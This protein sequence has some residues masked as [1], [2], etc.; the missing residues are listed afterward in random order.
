MSTREGGLSAP[1]RHPIDWENPAFYDTEALN[2]ELERVFDVCHGCRRC[3]SLCES[4][5]VLFDLVDQSTTLE[6]DGVA[7]EDYDKVVD[8]CFL[9]D[10]CY[11]TKCPYVPPHE[12]NI[13]FPHLMLR[14]KINKRKQKKP[15]LS[16]T[17]LS[18]TETVGSIAS[19]PVVRQVVNAANRSKPFRVALEKVLSVH[20]DAAVPPYQRLN[21]KR[22][23]SETKADAPNKV[24]LFAGCYANYNTPHLAEDLVAVFAHSGVALTLLEKEPCCGMPK[25]E[26]GDLD[27]VIALKDAMVDQLYQSVQA[28]YA[29]V[30]PVPSCV[31][32]I[33]Q[34][35]PLLFSGDPRIKAISNATYDPCEFLMRLHK[36]SMLNLSFKQSLGTVSYH[37]ACHQRVQNVGALTRQLLELVPDTTVHTI[38]RC[39]GH[40]GT[41]GVK[42]E[43]YPIAKK[44]VAPITKALAQKEPDHFCS[45]CSLAGN[46]IVSTYQKTSTA[47]EPRTYKN[48]HPLALLKLAYGLA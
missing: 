10:L 1:T 12:L 47:P 21:R 9:C 40:D 13:D 8:H 3:F 32:M 35:W 19:I 39:S 27:A 20:R 33:R 45:D 24:V 30:A 6:V 18:E 14:A 38:E 7:V 44:L 26:L 34:E 25:Y 28:G 2:Q 15:K 37:A 48:N 41:Y 36:K 43:T 31:L 46:H 11:M 4:F 22:L 23:V 5:P 42:K 16:H 17:I 29:I